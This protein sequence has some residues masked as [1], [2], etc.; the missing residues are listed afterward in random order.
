MTEPMIVT[1]D[2]REI[3]TATVFAMPVRIS[4]T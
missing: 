1:Y 4:V 3:S 2:A